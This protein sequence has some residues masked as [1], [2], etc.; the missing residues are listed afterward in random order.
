MPQTIDHEGY[1]EEVN[2]DNCA[3]EPIHIIGKTQAY[4]VLLVC[5]ALNLKITQ[6]GTN[7]EQFFS[8]PHEELLGQ[9]LSLLLKQEKID[10][11]KEA[12]AQKEISIPHE[13]EINGKK[14]L[15]LAHFSDINL[16]LDFEPLNEDRDPYFFQKQL[17]RILNKIKS[18]HSIEHLCRTATVLTK[19]MFGYDRVMVYRFDE[20][21]NGEV[22]AENKNEEMQSWLGLHYP[23]TDIPQQSRAMFLK[24]RVRVITNVDYEPVAL[25]PQL[26]PL[27]KDSLNLSRSSLRAVSP[28]HI[29]YLKNMDVGASLSAAIVVRGKL[30]GLIACHHNTAKYLDHYQRESCRFLAQMLSTEIELQET[31]S[32]ISNTELSEGLRQ[33]LVQQMRQKSEISEGLSRGAVKFTDLVSCGGGALFFNNSWT[34]VGQTPSEEQ[35]QELL[36]HLLVE[37]ESLY[38]TRRLAEEFPPAEAYKDVASGILSLRVS[39]NKYIMWFRPEVVQTVNWGGN[40]E[41]KAFYNEEKQRISPR[42]SVEKWSQQVNGISKDWKDCDISV[43]RALRENVSHLVLARQSE[44]IATLNEQLWQANEELELFSYGLSHDLRAPVRGV[45]GFLQILQEDFS[46]EMEPEAKELL[47][48]SREMMLK[49]NTLI[50]DILEYSGLHKS[51]EINFQEVEVN[52]LLQEIIEFYN[53]KT[54]YPAV[55]LEIS[56]RLP[57]MKGDR[58]MLFQLWSNLITNACKYSAVSQNARVEIGVEQQDGKKVYFVKDN[59][60]GFDQKHAAKI[61]STFSRVA[62]SK[63]EGSGIGLAIVKRILEKHG[64]EIWAKS[65]PGEGA[66]FYFSL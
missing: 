24:H 65:Q 18:T 51:G 40:P 52:P 56:E 61:F 27:T 15:M 19:Q 11:L 5:D 63:F 8:V 33:E 36:V 49:M 55:Q 22:I 29:E 1:P 46:E 31:N 35:V 54:L 32:Y 60:I 66:A 64:G 28:I 9:E 48:K 38:H 57:K 37:K 45:D 53:L 7:S 12:L 58:R 62:G 20:E 3:K 47:Q 34:F 6:A 42:K 2:L 59:G 44:E 50:D 39:E 16:V 13:V 10:A 23:T 17:S 14:F 25:V 43:A 30:W 26:S 41:K 21:W 4:G